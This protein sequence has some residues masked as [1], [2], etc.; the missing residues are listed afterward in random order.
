[1]QLPGV[2][3]PRAWPGVER[4]PVER[5]SLM[6]P[7][8]STEGRLRDPIEL[9]PPG[10]SSSNWLPL[11]YNYF[12]RA[13]NPGVPWS[14]KFVFVFDGKL[15]SRVYMYERDLIDFADLTDLVRR[16]H[17]HFR[18]RMFVRHPGYYWGVWEAIPDHRAP[19]L[20]WPHWEEELPWRQPRYCYDRLIPASLQ[21]WDT[22]Y[23]SSS[24]S[25]GVD[26]WGSVASD[27]AIDRE[28]Y[29]LDRK[30]STLTQRFLA[31]IPINASGNEIGKVYMSEGVILIIV[32]FLHWDI[33]IP[34]SRSLR[35]PPAVLLVPA[36]RL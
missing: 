18:F 16:G 30:R 2:E 26:T 13:H 33:G 8:R 11:R 36:R 34:L 15:W 17:T 29:F 14:P 9:A 3:R 21:Y 23:A 20:M 24:C 1:M 5:Q 19:T 7:M 32:Q 22:D 6:K 28:H 27:P 4:Q 10:H 35:P 31:Q 25:S 12:Y